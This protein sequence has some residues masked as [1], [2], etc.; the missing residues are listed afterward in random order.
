MDA[1]VLD[2]A[3]LAS[4]RDLTP[5]GE[6]DV[7]AEVLKMFLAEVPRR[8]DRLR[9]AYAAGDIEEVHRCAHSLKGSAG[10]IGARGLYATCKQLDDKAKAG[11]HPG[12]GPFVDA[13]T[14]EFSKVETAIHRL[15]ATS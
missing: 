2:A 5:A 6:P 13:L 9:I 11:D 3:V 8:L 14:V 10:N 1:P 4:L 15:I 12:A 7:L